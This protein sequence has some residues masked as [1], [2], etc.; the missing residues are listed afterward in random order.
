MKTI[1]EKI[2]NEKYKR[3][4]NLE[5]KLLNSKYDEYRR[6]KSY[7]RREYYSAESYDF[8]TSEYPDDYR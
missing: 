2:W 1:I 7:C 4:N 5:E 3:E 8:L 6:I